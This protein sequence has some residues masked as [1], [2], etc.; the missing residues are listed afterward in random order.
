MALTYTN[1]DYDTT[2]GSPLVSGT[3]SYTAGQP[4]LVFAGAPATAFNP[5]ISD[6]AGLTWS[7]LSTQ[8]GATGTVQ[9]RVFLAT[10]VSSGS[11]VISLANSASAVSGMRVKTHTGA[12]T[13]IVVG[14]AGPGTQTAYLISQLVSPTSNGSA[15]YLWIASSGAEAATPATPGSG[16]T[17]MGSS[18]NAFNNANWEL[19]PST[20][21]LTSNAA[22][23][24]STTTAGGYSQDLA[25]IA[26]EAPALPTGPTITAQPTTQTVNAGATATFSV[27]ATTSGG[28]L[29]Y[30]W[31]D[32][33][34]GS[35]ANITGATSSSYTTASATYAMQGWQ[36][37]CICTD[38]NGS[39]T[40]SIA[41]LLVAYNLS[42]TGIKVTFGAGYPSG[43]APVG[44][45]I[46]PSSGG[47]FN[48]S[49]SET[50]ATAD[51]PSSAM[52]AAPAVAE[53]AAT[54]DAP[55]ESSVDAVS[56]AETSA[57]SDAPSEG[58]TASATIAETS[59]TSDASTEALSASLTVA[60]TAATS[61]APSESMSAPATIAESVAATDAPASALVTPAAIAETSATSDAP[62]SS[63]TQAPVISETSATA[64]T[65]SAAMSASGLLAD[66][67][68]TSD[69]PSALAG[70]FSA[71]AE[72]IATLDQATASAIMAAIIAESAAIADGVT[73]AAIKA[74]SLAESMSS[75]DS[76]SQT[77]G[78]LLTMAESAAT[79]DAQSAARIVAALIAEAMQTADATGAAG[80]L[81]VGLS[82][83]S[84][85][86]DTIAA[87]AVL[88]AILQEL[89]QAT[90]AP[91]S[92]H[93]FSAAIVEFAAT[94][95]ETD[96]IVIAYTLLRAFIFPADPRVF[97]FPFETRLYTFPS[98]S[99]AY[100]FP[101]DSR[102][103]TFP[104]PNF[105]GVS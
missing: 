104:D 90:D 63:T 23:T 15:L 89:A 69:S 79:A 103:Y 26:I 18:Y 1:Y 95:D 97:S 40:S 66:S 92:I 71:I 31:Q 24:L 43:T 38:S 22:F 57:T 93:S 5:T 46:G 50:S 80:N 36:Q 7:T 25:W 59:A 11:T 37:Q 32:N 101:T 44:L 70:F 61:D 82:E 47:T 96:F 86:N 64:D 10:P 77:T 8:T 34:G 41:S 13:P 16:C 98:D 74:V 29:T 68:S 62:S 2:S 49:I 9:T 14:G 65:P 28:T 94:N 19:L 56:V 100:A 105:T 81:L 75:A 91:N 3:I 12:G 27:S 30:Q 85:A 60:E 45:F 52:V 6:T 88:A 76:P 20:N 4:I 51:T 55:S 84:S 83:S 72:S 33:S 102:T 54:S 42:G 48:L 78:T 53:T 17:Q 58:L 39:I 21:P 87:S 67:V 99:R 35:F 73:E